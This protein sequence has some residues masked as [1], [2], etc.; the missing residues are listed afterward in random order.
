[1]KAQMGLIVK[2]IDI[3]CIQPEKIEEVEERSQIRSPEEWAIRLPVAASSALLETAGT[4]EG[5]HQRVNRHSPAMHTGS[6]SR[7]TPAVEAAMCEDELEWVI[8][9]R[10]KSKFRFYRFDL[11]CGSTTGYPF[12][13]AAELQTASETWPTR[14]DINIINWGPRKYSIVGWYYIQMAN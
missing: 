7:N 6:G 1:M 8:D 4:D 5:D 2:E 3:L 14:I 12:N 13:D 10:N 9:S 11:L